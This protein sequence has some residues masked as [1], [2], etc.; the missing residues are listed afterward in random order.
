M[1]FARSIRPYMG[2]AWL[3]MA[4]LL[5]AASPAFAEEAE[6]P[7]A[8]LERLV[9]LTASGAHEFSVE[10]MR[11][12]SQREHGLMFRRYLPQ[13]R[14]MLFDFGVER[15]VMMWMKNTYLPLDMIFIG[16]SGQVVGFAEHAEPLSQKII[17]SGAPAY[18]VLEVK[19]GTAAEIGLKIGDTVR[20][21]LFGN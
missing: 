15:P 4:F 21:P 13:N 2:W 19:A 10:V 8:G 3:S 14:G 11:T 18:G 20:H 1:F 17:P 9:I 6:P 7:Q 5:F 16:R 12:E